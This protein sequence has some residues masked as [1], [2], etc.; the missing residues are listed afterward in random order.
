MPVPHPKLIYLYA[1]FWPFYFLTCH[2][3]ENYFFLF[4]NN[5]PI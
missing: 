3:D 1:A 5:T 4:Q 2:I